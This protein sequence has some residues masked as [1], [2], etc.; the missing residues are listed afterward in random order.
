[1]GKD[2][3]KTLTVHLELLNHPEELNMFS[4]GVTLCGVLLLVY[5]VASR[6]LMWSVGLCKVW[7]V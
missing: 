2:N 1:M 7:C 3:S 5:S 6:R 4:S